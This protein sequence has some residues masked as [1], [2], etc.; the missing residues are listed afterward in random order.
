MT[1]WLYLARTIDA[2]NSWVGGAVSWLIL[3][4]TLV[5]AGNAVSRRFFDASS[6]AFLEIQWYLFAAVFLLAAGYTLL[7]DAHVRIDLVTGRLAPRLRLWI[8]LLTTL[9]FLF[10]I[11]MLVLRYG[12][13]YFLDS[14]A[15]REVSLNSG[16]LWVWP[17]KF[18]ISAGFALLFL[19][20]VSQFIKIIAALAG[21]YPIE[22][23]HAPRD[24]T[25]A[26]M[27]S[28]QQ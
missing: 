14:V 18:L 23:L 2:F 1:G 21:A 6:N 24:A 8:E 13:P 7:R 15:N 25:A 10:P 11:T 3:A 12:W 16:G 20:G 28:T 4:M 9:L 19:Q 22:A 27:S 17:V 26:R 5:S